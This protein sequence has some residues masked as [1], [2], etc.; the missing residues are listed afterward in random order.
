M[1]LPARARDECGLCTR[2][3][4]SPMDLAGIICTCVFWHCL[5]ASYPIVTNEEKN[6]SWLARDV[7]PTDE[8]RLFHYS[9]KLSRLFV[10]Y[11]KLVNTTVRS[12]QTM[13]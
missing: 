2:Y 3:L 5:I 8:K 12:S 13:K 11:T 1:G 9:S 4:L 10:V 6:F 7:H